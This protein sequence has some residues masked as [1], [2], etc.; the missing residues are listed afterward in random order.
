MQFHAKMKLNCYPINFLIKTIVLRS[1]SYMLLTLIS[2]TLVVMYKSNILNLLYVYIYIYI[3]ILTCYMFFNSLSMA[4][5]Q[6]S[7][8]SKELLK[9]SQI[10]NYF[11]C[12]YLLLNTLLE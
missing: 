2:N 8:L 1:M 7:N 12:H 4:A 5:A 11:E 9:R 3:Y 10:T 6:N